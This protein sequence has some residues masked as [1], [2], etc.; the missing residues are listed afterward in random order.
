[1]QCLSPPDLRNRLYRAGWGLVWLTLFRPSP[2]PL[3][4]WRRLLL[5]LFGAVVEN[6]TAIYP[7]ARI[8]APNRLVMRRGSCLAAQTDC[9]NVA[10]VELAADCVVSQKAY[11][12]TASHDFDDPVFPLIG[13]PI[14]V[15]AGAWVAAAAF[16]G[17]GVHIGERAVVAATATVTR[18]VDPA[19][20]VAGN[21]ARV[22]RHRIGA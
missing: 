18:N 8:W 9:Y 15:G 22:V 7:S 13:A 17:P 20:V 3:H 14:S 19:A 6:D 10:L 16:V 11:L 2:V 21:P 5:R 12:C 1:M 4:A